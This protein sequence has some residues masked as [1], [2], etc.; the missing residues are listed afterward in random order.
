MPATIPKVITPKSS[1]PP[2]LTTAPDILVQTPQK[3]PTERGF[4][5]ANMS[6]NI[7]LPLSLSCKSFHKRKFFIFE[8]G[9]RMVPFNLKMLTKFGLCS[10]CLQKLH[11]KSF[12]MVKTKSL[13]HSYLWL[14]CFFHSSAFNYMYSRTLIVRTI[15]LSRLFSLV[16]FLMNINQLSS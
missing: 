5:D 15:R 10:N 6:R 4:S 12:M 3:L 13:K 9:Y 16:C 7:D 14:Q 8:Q 2:F 11:D 1:A